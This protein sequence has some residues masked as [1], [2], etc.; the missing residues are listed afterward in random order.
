MSKMITKSACA[1]IGGTTSSSRELATKSDLDA[2]GCKI[3]DNPSHGYSDNQCV[4][5]EDVANKTNSKEA[6]MGSILCTIKAENSD[7]T[8][9]TLGMQIQKFYGYGSDVMT[10]YCANNEQSCI[11]I[12]DRTGRQVNFT[13]PHRP[14]SSPYF[15]VEEGDLFSTHAENSY[16]REIWYDASNSVQYEPPFH[17]ADGSDTDYAHKFYMWVKIFDT[18][19][20]EF[21]I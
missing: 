16:T 2:L 19:T 1:T 7:A 18:G 6:V 10:G 9:V 17:F 20:Q 13:Y 4:Q 12:Y 3:K 21:F 15:Y 5:A 14:E 11:P 8:K